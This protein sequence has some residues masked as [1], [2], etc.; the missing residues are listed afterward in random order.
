[1]VGEWTLRLYFTWDCVWFLK[2]NPFCI[3]GASSPTW[4]KTSRFPLGFAISSLES[5]QIGPFSTFGAD[6]HPCWLNLGFPW[7]MGTAKSKNPES[8][9]QSCVGEIHCDSKQCELWP[10]RLPL[11][12]WHSSQLIRFSWSSKVNWGHT[13]RMVPSTAWL[14]WSGPQWWFQDRLKDGFWQWASKRFPPAKQYFLCVFHAA[15]GG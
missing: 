8:W 11:N 2:C 3:R 10:D 14:D 7:K 6:W 15:C 5:G 4:L 9:C 12:W 13:V 1:M